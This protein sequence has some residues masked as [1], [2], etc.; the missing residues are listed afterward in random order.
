MQVYLV[1]HKEAK[2]AAIDGADKHLCK[3]R[4]IANELWGDKE[5][6]RRRCSN[7]KRPSAIKQLPILGLRVLKHL[8]DVMRLNRAVWLAPT[9]F[10]S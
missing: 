5:E 7:S 1:K 8:V 2:D 3:I 4:M 9:N 10:A 6:H